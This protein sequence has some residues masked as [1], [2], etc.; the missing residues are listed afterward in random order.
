MAILHIPSS[1]CDCYCCQQCCLFGSCI[2]P[3]LSVS[4]PMS[5]PSQ[6][7]LLI[8]A[9]VIYTLLALFISPASSSATDIQNLGNIRGF[10]TT[11][12]NGA[13]VV[14]H[15][16]IGDNRI[17]TGQTGVTNMFNLTLYDFTAHPLDTSTVD[18]LTPNVGQPDVGWTYYWDY[19][20]NAYIYG[21][22]FL[23]YNITTDPNP[24]SARPVVEASGDAFSASSWSGYWTWYWTPPHWEWTWVWTWPSGGCVYITR[25]ICNA[26]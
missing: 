16:Y 18:I 10:N 1:R 4:Q 15:A 8:A 24:P 21:P 19:N 17:A 3:S 26:D 7:W 6:R 20:T 23:D 12:V 13:T 14:E 5:A 11:T 25:C 2:Y 22:A 9:A